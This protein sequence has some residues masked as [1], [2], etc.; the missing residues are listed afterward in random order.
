M[1]STDV[2]LFVYDLSKGLAKQL[3]LPLIGKQLDGIWH[4]SIV[5]F[6]REY[7][8][9]GGG[10][11]SC[12]PCGTILGKPEKTIRLGETQVTYAILLEY[13]HELGEEKYTGE[14]YNLF[15]H[16][17]NTFSNEVA[18][19][20]TGSKIPDYVSTLPQEVMDTPIGAMLKSIMDSMTANPIAKPGANASENA[21]IN[22]ISK[23][24]KEA[25]GSSKEEEGRGK[26]SEDG[27][28]TGGE[29]A[30]ESGENIEDVLMERLRK[31]KMLERSRL[32]LFEESNPV[33]CVEAIKTNLPKGLLSDGEITELEN[34]VPCLLASEDDIYKPSITPAGFLV[35]GR[36]LCTVDLPH[37]LLLPLVDLLQL[38]FLD[39]EIIK[40]QKENDDHA[41]MTFVFLLQTYSLDVQVSIFRLLCN[42]CSTR[43]GSL[44]LK[45]E[46]QW[47]CP[48]D[49]QP[50]SNMQLMISLIVSSLLSTVLDLII[51]SATLVYNMTRHNISED[52]VVE[53]SSALIQCLT[54]ELTEEATY[55][56]LQ[57][58]FGLMPYG[59]VGSLMMVMGWIQPGTV[60]CQ[61]GQPKYARK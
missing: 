28:D 18:S 32:V 50:T 45:A 58:L 14:K 13:L 23:G 8:F 21:A 33:A 25:S 38:V 61:R 20:L 49:G 35:L 42:A 47:V 36:L 40:E 7:F 60:P 34:L 31:E 6:N 51:A 29:N 17:C 41:I 16:N 55:R 59:E 3:S 53:V 48:V 39:P 30:E 44:W 54:I 11:E 9:G 5:I 26:A 15:Q 12:R 27:K 52:F 1:A 57:A 24:Q 46:Q 22:G 2:L 43:K 37:E 4:T 10:I 56:C 19:F